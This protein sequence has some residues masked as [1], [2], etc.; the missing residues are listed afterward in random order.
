[1]G[2]P[3]IEEAFVEGQCLKGK[4]VLVTGASRGIGRAVAEAF[5]LAGA[6]V[7]ANYN[8]SEKELNA[9]VSEL[10]SKGCKIEAHQA[11]VTKGAAVEKMV[12]EIVTKYERIDILVNNAGVKKDTFM[13]MM[14][15]EEWDKVIEGNLKSVFLLTKWA[16]R[17]MMRQRSGKIVNISSLSAF[18]GLPGQTNYAASKGGVI[19]FTRAAARELGRF[20]IQ[21]NAIAPGLIETD[22]LKGMD[23]AVIEEMKKAIPL[24]RLGDV[25]DVVAAAF[26]LA[27]DGSN[28]M[29]GQSIILDGGLSA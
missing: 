28:Y 5:A 22:M 29:T 13:A 7:I 14:N 6:Q 25:K 9:L 18:K 4:V 19:S 21:I 10:R 17:A 3:V 20:G 15:E 16:S 2:I 23:P 11:D 24:G 12:D 26:Y 27:G 1:M 8:K